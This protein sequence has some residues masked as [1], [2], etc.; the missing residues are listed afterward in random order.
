V[1]QVKQKISTA[2]MI[3]EHSVKSSNRKTNG[4]KGAICA[5]IAGLQFLLLLL[6]KQ[7]KLQIRV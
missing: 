6:I 1:Y 5:G 7:L 4:T 2:N 3:S